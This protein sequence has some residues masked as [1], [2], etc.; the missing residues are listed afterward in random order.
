MPVLYGAST[1]LVGA[2][3]W[4]YPDPATII[5]VKLELSTPPAG[6]SG[7]V[8]STVI[9]W[10]GIGA[11]APVDE[12]A[13]LPARLLWNPSVVEYDIGKSPTGLVYEWENDAQVTATEILSEAPPGP[14]GGGGTVAVMQVSMGSYDGVA[15]TTLEYVPLDTIAFQSDTTSYT[16]A[17]GGITVVNAGYYRVSWHST[18]QPPTANMYARVYITVNG[19]DDADAIEVTGVTS[20]GGHVAGGYKER[21]LAAGDTV[22]LQVYQVSGA[23]QVMTAADLTVSTG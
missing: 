14:G 22:Q 15:D 8:G 7:F 18:W 11:W 5:G 12:A 21:S 9:R 3:T 13:Q 17:S 1:V 23:T 20:D 19:T 4:T 16:F 2:G 6:N 10:R